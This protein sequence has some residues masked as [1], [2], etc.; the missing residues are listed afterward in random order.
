MK[1]NYNKKE[2]YRAHLA[3][4]ARFDGKFFVAVRTTMIYCRPICPAR[5]AQLKN[6][7]F[8]L[9]AA[10]AEAAGFR[11]CLRCRPETAPGS[12][13]WLGTSAIVQRALRVMDNS[14]LEELSV[15]DL[16]LIL[17][18]GER[19][20]R[21][22]FQQQ[23]GASP[24]A[25]LMSKKLGLARNLLDESSLSITDIAFSSGF[26][27]LRRFNDAFKLRFLKTPS[28]FRKSPSLEGTLRFQLSYRPPYAWKNVIYFLQQRSIPSIELVEDDSYQRLFTFG[29]VRGWF[30][31]THA[32]HRK[33]NVEMKLSKNLN[34]LE[35]VARIKNIF[36]LDADP[37]IIE[38]TLREDEILRPFLLQY[39]GLRVVGCW[40]GFELAVRAVVG[41]RI[42]VKAAHAILCKIVATCGEK[43]EFDST[44][45]LS[46]FFPTPENILA[47]DLSKVGL[48]VA[49]VETLKILAREI[50]DGCLVL[51]GTADFEETCQKLLAIKGI[52]P[53]TVEYIAMRAL[54]NPNAFP[55]T[56]LELQ[57]RVK[58]LHLDPQKWTPWRAYGA[59][60]LLAIN[61]EKSKIEE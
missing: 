46:R 8:F 21:E 2:F 22:L 42:S 43:Q 34:I 51:D 12:A 48:P 56:D 39:S 28:A 53:W 9:H 47:A 52:G 61:L 33:I 23:V 27:S 19:W 40:D 25:I 60:L 17:G 36:D 5:K 10:Q 45:K 7:E 49:R 58:H 29:E 6:L 37:M 15:K 16:A 24:Q 54:K 31:V 50:I 1:M 55:A 11:P 57:K 38:A 26:Q 44:L 41:Q 14:V 59:I 13:A 32:S 18:I 3:R 35:F 4:D 30:R 20:L